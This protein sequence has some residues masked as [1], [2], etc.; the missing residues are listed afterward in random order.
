MNICTGGSTAIDFPLPSGILIN[1]EFSSEKKIYGALIIIYC[2]TETAPDKENFHFDKVLAETK[3]SLQNFSHL[4]F[5][6]ISNMPFLLHP[7]TVRV[8]LCRVFSYHDPT[9]D[10]AHSF[11]KVGYIIPVCSRSIPRS[12]FFTRMTKNSLTIHRSD[13]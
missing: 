9:F 5:G 8:R 11:H 6:G 2:I 12:H 4:V 7:P 3:P 1:S 10:P 13:S